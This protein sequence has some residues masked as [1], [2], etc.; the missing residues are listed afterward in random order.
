MI[1]QT[2]TPWGEPR[3]A[4]HYHAVSLGN[5]WEETSTYGGSLAEN[6]TQ[7]VARDL[8]AEA[9]LSLDAAGHRIVMHVHDEI[10]VEV[11]REAPADT[12]KK[13]EKIVAT[14]PSWA[15]DLPLAAEGWRGF[16]YRK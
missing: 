3:S 11:S 13:I 4:L 1:R 10:V 7:A 5:H 12:L 8:L 14:P 6:V 15:K 2:P 9:M 16:R